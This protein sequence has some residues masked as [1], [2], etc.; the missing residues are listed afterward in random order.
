MVLDLRK[1]WFCR[2]Y[3]EDWG[4]GNTMPGFWLDVRAKAAT[5]GNDD[6]LKELHRER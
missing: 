1:H 5:G 3:I 4:H 2:N 6:G